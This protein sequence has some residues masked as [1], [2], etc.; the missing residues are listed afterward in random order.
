MATEAPSLDLTIHKTSR[1]FT[2]GI[3][4]TLGPTSIR[5]FIQTLEEIE[6]ERYADVTLDLTSV[7]RVD[8][9]AVRALTGHATRT[10]GRALTLRIVP[11]LP[12]LYLE[13]IV[14]TVKDASEARRALIEIHRASVLEPTPEV[15]GEMKAA[16][17]HPERQLR[18]TSQAILDAVVDLRTDPILL[19]RQ[20]DHPERGAWRRVARLTAA[21]GRADRELH[22]CFLELSAMAPPLRTAADMVVRALTRSI[23][24]DDAARELADERLGPID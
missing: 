7:E 6:S 19:R 4:G 13:A 18:D 10:V 16:I 12:T 23:A 14:A 20:E 5:A 17:L 1:S 2:L 22:A 11:S 21:A 3:A 15:R 8:L 9:P 24:A